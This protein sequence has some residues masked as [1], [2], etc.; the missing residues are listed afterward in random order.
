MKKRYKLRERKRKESRKA[1]HTC[2]NDKINKQQRTLKQYNNPCNIPP[3]T[4]SLPTW[5]TLLVEGLHIGVKTGHF[6]CT[7]RSG[8]RAGCAIGHQTEAGAAVVHVIRGLVV[9]ALNSWWRLCC[10]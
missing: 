6:S 8:G 5:A 10:R 1:Q 4:I 9:G 7:P 2:T 3:F